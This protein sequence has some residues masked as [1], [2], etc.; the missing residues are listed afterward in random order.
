[1]ILVKS[2]FPQQG[3][4]FKKGPLGGPIFSLEIELIE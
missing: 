4:K 2:G 3:P 1:M